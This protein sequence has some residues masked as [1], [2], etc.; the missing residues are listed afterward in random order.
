M[1]QFSHA[2]A[3]VTGAETGAEL[4]DPLRVLAITRS[5]EHEL[6]HL[7]MREQVV[8]L[9]ESRLARDTLK[10]ALIAWQ[11]LPETSR[12]S[13]GFALEALTALRNRFGSGV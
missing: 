13:S 9:V 10:H 11:L 3:K 4:E 5:G 8:D 2:I 6:E 12:Y 7:K 1:T